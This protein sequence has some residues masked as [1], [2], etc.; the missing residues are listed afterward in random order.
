MYRIVVVLLISTSV[1]S[2]GQIVER[3]PFNM[4]TEFPQAEL[5]G[6]GRGSL[7]FDASMNTYNPHYLSPEGADYRL[8]VGAN[9]GFAGRRTYPPQGEL[10]TSFDADKFTNPI[11]PTIGA[12]LWS[13]RSMFQLCYYQDYGIKDHETGSTSYGFGNLYRVSSRERDI[14]L[15]QCTFQVAFSHSILPS[16]SVTV[17][18]LTKGFRY[19][20]DI[21]SIPPVVYEHNMFEHFQGVVG[22]MVSPLENLQSYLTLTSQN[23]RIDLS[24]GVFRFPA[25]ILVYP[26]LTK[27]SYYGNIG[28]GVQVGVL[29]QL[30]LSV[31]MRHQFLEDSSDVIESDGFIAY[32]ERHIWNNEIT[33]GAHT[34]ILSTVQLGLRYSRF[35]K[36]DNRKG[37]IRTSS[38]GMNSTMS[39]QNPYSL[40]VVS[41]VT[42]GDLSMEVAYQYAKA[43][44]EYQGQT[45]ISDAVH[46]ASVLIGYSFSLE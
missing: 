41:Q 23:S 4:F 28:Y 16:C 25:G 44:Y 26:T 46:S 17:G 42:L 3:P 20:W 12:I 6:Y 14:R 19:E 2:I 38:S 15:R 32:G 10:S 8:L 1:Q 21:K 43:G 24:D 13:G 34:S 37:M 36:Y 33:V 27:I 40:A 30:K 9:V 35:L 18:L 45:A 22:I 5:R 31:E 39:I 29:Q 11:N 7:G